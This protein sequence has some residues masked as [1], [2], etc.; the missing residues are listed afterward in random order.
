MADYRR[1]TGCGDR[2]EPQRHYHR[3]CWTCWRAQD[4][5]PWWDSGPRTRPIVEKAVPVLDARTIRAAVALCH[6]D[7]HP[8]ERAEAANRVTQ[9]LTSALARVRELEAGA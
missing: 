6:P 3:L 1:C 8:P 9:S 5:A 2:F 4:D 7:V